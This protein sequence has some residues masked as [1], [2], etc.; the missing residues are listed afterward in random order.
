MTTTAATLVE[1]TGSIV[2]H[3]AEVHADGCSD[4]DKK[5]GHKYDGFES[6]SAAVQDYVSSDPDGFSTAD[7]VKVFPCAKR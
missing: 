6:V 2:A 7:E 1:L 4:L 5:I 3:R